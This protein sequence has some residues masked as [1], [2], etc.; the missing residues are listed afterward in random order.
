MAQS[1]TNYTKHDYSSLATEKEGNVY[2][3]SGYACYSGMN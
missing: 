3:K 1:H 2:M